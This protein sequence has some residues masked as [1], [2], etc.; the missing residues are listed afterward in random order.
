MAIISTLLSV[1]VF[2]AVALA[3]SPNVPAALKCISENYDLYDL[4]IITR[5]TPGYSDASKPYN[6]RLKTD[7][8]IIVVP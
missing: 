4:T 6:L 7:P 2:A 8:S 3:W 1:S 5:S